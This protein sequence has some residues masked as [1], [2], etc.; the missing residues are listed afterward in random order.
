MPKQSTISR[1][2]GLAIGSMLVTAMLIPSTALAGKAQ[3]GNGNAS[4]SAS[5]KEANVVTADAGSAGDGTTAVM[6]TEAGSGVP[7]TMSAG[8]C[9]KMADIPFPS[10]RC[11]AKHARV[12]VNVRDGNDAVLSKG[13]ASFTLNGGSGNDNLTGSTGDDK[14]NGGGGD[15]TL[16]GGDGSD[17]IRGNAGSDQIDAA[18][19]GTPDR[20]N[21]GGGNDT[22]ATDLDPVTKQPVGDVIAKNCETV[23]QKTDDFS[24]NAD[25][26]LFGEYPGDVGDITTSRAQRTAPRSPRWA[27][28]PR[29]ASARRS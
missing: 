23:V 14:V 22:V 12:L 6:V 18:D 27:R 1:I 2:V 20:I 13:A 25:S 24:C 26:C 16:R 4:F 10:V 9:Q 21:C 19:N 17:V 8:S 3:G 28:T 29:S 7:L 5:A 15:D 11:T